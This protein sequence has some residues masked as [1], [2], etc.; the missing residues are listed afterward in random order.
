MLKI[1]FKVLIRIYW[2]I[3]PNRI[4]GTCLFDET[5]SRYVYRHLEENGF[6]A[7]ITALKY[8]YKVCRE[9]FVIRKNKSSNSLELHLCNGDIVNQKEINSHY[10]N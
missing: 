5:C 6:R 2:L 7:G 3:I 8:R 4:K 9:P 1:G 10:L